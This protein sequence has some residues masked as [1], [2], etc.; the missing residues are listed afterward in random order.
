MQAGL[1]AYRQ[2]LSDRAAR[3][4]SLAGVLAR[5]PLSMTGIGVVLLVSLT[6]GSFGRA[7]LITAAGTLTGAVAA[8]LWGRA[9]DRVGQATG[10]A[11]R[12]RPSTACPWRC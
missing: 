9:I 1:G 3:A 11:A 7:G 2:L 5:L 4:F 8:P 10:A 12:A 6:T